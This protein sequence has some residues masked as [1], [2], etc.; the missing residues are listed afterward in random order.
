ML[1]SLAQ[2]SYNLLFGTEIVLEKIN[3][4]IENLLKEGPFRDS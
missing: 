4:I 1:H 2:L 3:G